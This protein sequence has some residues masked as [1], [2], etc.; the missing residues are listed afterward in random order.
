MLKIKIYAVKK[1][2]IMWARDHVPRLNERARTGNGGQTRRTGVDERSAIPI[3]VNLFEVNDQLVRVMLCKRKDFG[4]KKGDN[5]I[6][7]DLDRLVAEVR[8]VNTEV[9]VKPLDLIHYELAGDESL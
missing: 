9:R 6:R 4:A 3:R 1:Q 2:K 7:D 8:V 5:M